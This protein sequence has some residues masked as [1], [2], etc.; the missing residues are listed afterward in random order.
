MQCA[1][2]TEATVQRHIVAI[3]ATGYAAEHHAGFA[4][5]TG[6]LGRAIGCISDE[7]V[8]AVAGD[9]YPQNYLTPVLELLRLTAWRL[10]W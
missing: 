2:A 9:G 4:F 3:G 1:A 8:V 7:D 6:G 10:A 5:L